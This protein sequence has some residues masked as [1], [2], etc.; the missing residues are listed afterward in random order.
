[1]ANTIAKAIGHDSS[2]IKETHRLGSRFAQAEA[3]T[4]RTFSTAFVAAD[5]SGY[6]EVIRDGKTVHRF[7]FGKES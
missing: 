5:G 6:V 4:W 7:D 2:R 3:N 1:M